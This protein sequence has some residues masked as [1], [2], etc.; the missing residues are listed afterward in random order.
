MI[1]PITTSR[2][3]VRWNGRTAATAILTLLLL[4]P[5]SVSAQPTVVAPGGGTAGQRPFRLMVGFTTGVPIAHLGG[6]DEADQGFAA[7][8]AGF[9]FRGYLPLTDQ[10]DLAFDLALPRFKVRTGEF[11]QTTNV[12]LSEAKYMGKMLGMGLRMFVGEPEWGKPFVLVT[13]GMYQLTFDR[14]L[15]G[16]QRITRGAFRPGAAVGGGVEFKIGEFDVEGTLRYHRFTD[17]GNFG[18]GDLSWIEIGF[19]LDLQVAG[20]GR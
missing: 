11:I 10:V 15:A 14:F 3:S 17:T 2:V 5:I 9:V 1:R 6:Q 13:G 12:H 16:V 8:D 20:R 19:G 18:L 7:P 4:G